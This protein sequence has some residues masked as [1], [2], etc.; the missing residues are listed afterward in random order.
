M[1]GSECGDPASDS[2]A[3]TGNRYFQVLQEKTTFD[4][5]L[6]AHL[7][8]EPEGAKDSFLYCFR[9]MLIVV[10][11]KYIWISLPYRHV[12]SFA[13]GTYSRPTHLLL[14]QVSFETDL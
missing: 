9:S 8:Q 1:V 6:F 5:L 13:L 14:L 12:D 11:Q 10:I 4:H 7:S 3:N 2:G